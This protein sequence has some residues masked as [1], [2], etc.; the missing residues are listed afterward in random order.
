M[1]RGGALDGY[2]LTLAIDSLALALGDKWIVICIGVQAASL[3]L[4]NCHIVIKPLG[5]RGSEQ[6]LLACELT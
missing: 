6:A 3:G 5:G 4:V 1:R 2:N